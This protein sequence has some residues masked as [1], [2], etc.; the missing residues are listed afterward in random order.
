MRQLLL[1]VPDSVHA[2]I[3]ARAAREGR[4]IN[5]VATE[6]IDAAADADGGSRTERLRA[7][8]AA[9]GILV[10]VPGAPVSDERRERILAGTVG[11]GQIA[12]QLI[13]EQRDRL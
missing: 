3:A 5:A 7:D 1:R 10:N 2:R 13:A 11:L 8:A 9:A 12:D 4:S 6:I